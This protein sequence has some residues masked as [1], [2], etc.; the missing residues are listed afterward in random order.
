MFYLAQPYSHEKQ[1]IRD[2]RAMWGMAAAASLLRRGYHVYA[3]IVHWHEAAKFY[4]LP[5]DFEFWQYH[6]LHMLELASDFGMLLLDGWKESTGLM[7]ELQRAV[8]FQKRIFRVLIREETKI[9]NAPVVDIFQI[10]L[11]E[12]VGM[13]NGSHNQK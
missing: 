11:K 1:I 10:S 7:S 3:P 5:T 2:S 9:K 13:V 12:A 4:K 8:D 6:N